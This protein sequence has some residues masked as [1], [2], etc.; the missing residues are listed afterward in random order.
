MTGGSGTEKYAEVLFP[1]GT[2]YCALPS[3]TQSHQCHTQS[4][5]L[6]CGDYG[7]ESKSC[8]KFEAGYWT[9]MTNNLL[10][11]R[12]YHSSWSNQDGNILLIGGSISPTTTEI[13]YQNG[14]SIRSFDL[15]YSIE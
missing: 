5:L 10:V 9:S 15:E 6:A 13:V 14:T 11:D 7:N 3:P 4:G 1:N 2:S 12:S 8:T